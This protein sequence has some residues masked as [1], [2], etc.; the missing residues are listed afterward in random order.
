MRIFTGA[1]A[2]RTLIGGVAAAAALTASAAAAAAAPHGDDG[3]G[4]FLLTSGD[5]VAAVL[6]GPD[7]GVHPDPAGA[8]ETIRAAGGDFENL[9]AEQGAMC[10]MI[11]Q[12]T[13]AHAWG[14]W[15]G[16]DGIDPVEFAADYGN[17][18]MAA[19]QSGG[20]FGF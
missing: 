11:L 6:C 8:C 17:P 13:P 7:V 10:T 5:D 15:S 20:V 16:A 9:P 18:C 4:A 14:V 12:P 3:V 1:A 2:R 19:A